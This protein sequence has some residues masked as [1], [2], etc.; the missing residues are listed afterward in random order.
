VTGGDES[1]RYAVIDPTGE[2]LA[3]RGDIARLAGWWMSRMVH[4]Q[5]PLHARLALFWHNHFATGNQK[6]NSPPLMLR[7]LRTIERHALGRLDELLL[8][9]SRDP[10]MI[11]WLDGDS[12]RK[13]HP[14]E[15]YARELFEL[16]SLGPGN[17][18][19]RDLREAARAFSGWHQ[20]EGQFFFN[21]RLHDADAKTIFGRTGRFD[22]ADV[23]ALAVDQP[24]CASFL[25]HKL[26]REF[27]CDQPPAALTGEL[28][29]VIRAEKFDIAATM[30]V[31]L[32]S[33]AFFDPAFYR[34]RIK[35]PVEFCI[36]LVRSF[37]MRAPGQQIHSAASQMGQR[38]FEP[39]TVKGW[40]GHR[41][42]I[43]SSN[44]L[45]RMNVA[46]V[47][48]AGN[49]GKG[50]DAARRVT[51]W[52]LGDADDAV[53]RACDLMLDDEVTPEL[54]ASLNEACTGTPEAALRTA[55]AAIAAS[56]EYQL[57]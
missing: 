6:V 33:R 29:D 43:N 14:N 3:A 2:A 27:V 12:N 31:L 53:R 39:P 28:G 51:E 37:E 34:A 54:L 45:V 5:R 38:L 49:D 52:Q 19:E 26:L 18:S 48:A 30:R 44:M 41:R 8:A 56:P 4:T 20:R 22:G 36:G 35:S 50:L 23:V 57:A 9:V 10:A 32:T 21:E 13:D 40:E 47:A 11:I 46:T 17:Y 42:W 7:Q 1:S 25:A 15:N 16:F 55:V 24:A